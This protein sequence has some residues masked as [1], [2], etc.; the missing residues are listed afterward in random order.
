MKKLLTSVLFLSLLAFSGFAFGNDDEPPSMTK[1][2]ER[3]ASGEMAAQATLGAAYYIGYGGVSQNYNEAFKWLYKAAEQG[4]VESQELVGIMYRSG[5][6]DVPE[7]KE[8][9]KE[10][11]SRS[12]KGGNPRACNHYEKLTGSPLPQ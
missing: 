4:D 8:K 12:C 10:Y 1:L 3:A 6:G 9:A 2:K 11:F 7:D 5:Q